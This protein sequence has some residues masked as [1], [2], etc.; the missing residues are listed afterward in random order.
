MYN[1]NLQ[2]DA[3]KAVGMTKA[4]RAKYFRLISVERRNEL[5]DYFGFRDKK[6]KVVPIK[7]INK[8]YEV[9]KKNR[10]AISKAKEKYVCFYS[11]IGDF[12]P[13]I[14]G[15]QLKNLISNSIGLPAKCIKFKK[16]GGEGWI[17]V[18]KEDFAKSRF[19]S[20][21]SYLTT[22]REIRA[23]ILGALHVLYEN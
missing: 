17:C 10:E 11:F 1:Y 23:Y 9:L 15:S 8:L 12:N 4:D 18:S 19:M 21:S 2:I 16:V 3:S 13:V 5:A 6:E 22:E 14:Y 20:R 7:K